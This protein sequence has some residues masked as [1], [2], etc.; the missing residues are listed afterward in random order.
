MGMEDSIWTDKLRKKVRGQSVLF[1]A[2][3]LTAFD[4]QD[5]KSGCCSA[6]SLSPGG[7]WTPRK[8]QYWRKRRK[9]KEVWEVREGG[10]IGV[11]S[12]YYFPADYRVCCVC[13]VCRVQFLSTPLMS[14]FASRS[15]FFLPPT[16]RSVFCKVF[17]PSSFCRLLEKNEGNRQAGLISNAQQQ[18]QQQWSHLTCPSWARLLQ[19]SV[20]LS[21]LQFT[22]VQKEGEKRG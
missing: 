16:S 21:I 15:F 1:L 19:Q 2:D 10:G 17:L 3:Q 6:T 14:S 9:Q 11:L 13:A 18:Q 12:D 8:E 5:W 7:R 22:S 4:H 20:C